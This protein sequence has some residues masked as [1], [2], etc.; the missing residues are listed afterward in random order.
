VN[1]QGEVFME[2]RRA[3]TFGLTIGLAVVFSQVAVLA[4]GRN[5]IYGTIYSEE[6][7]PLADVYVDLLDDFNAPLRHTRTDGI[8]RFTDSQIEGEMLGVRSTSNSSGHA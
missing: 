2:R 4:Q 1:L 6:R 7:R 8:G 3:L 5:Q